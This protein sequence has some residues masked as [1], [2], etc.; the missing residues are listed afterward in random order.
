[1]GLRKFVLNFLDPCVPHGSEKHAF[2]M[3]EQDCTLEQ[4]AYTGRTELLATQGMRMSCDR[5]LIPFLAAAGLALSACAGDAIKERMKVF[6][7]LPASAV[8]SKLGYPQ[9]QQ[10]VAGKKIYAWTSGGMYRGTS[11][12]CTFRVIVDAQDIITSWDVQGNEAQCGLY[13]TALNR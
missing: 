1:M 4:S 7:G 9:Q 2:G 13:A 11:H 10:E 12:D 3:K 5:R 6:V 8:F